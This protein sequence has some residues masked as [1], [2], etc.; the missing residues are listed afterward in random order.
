MGQQTVSSIET[1]KGLNIIS[2]VINGVNI[3]ELSEIS[4]KINEPSNLSGITFGL[5]HYT[6]L[7]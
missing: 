2:G 1:L 6:L 4:V 5:Y 7:I 3:T